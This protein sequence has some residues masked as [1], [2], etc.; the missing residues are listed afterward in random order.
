M[1]SEDN[2]PTAL[3]AY[4]FAGG[5]TLGV[6]K[7]FN[8]VGHLEDG[9]FG[10]ETVKRNQPGFPIF[11]DR[12]AW[13]ID[14][15][16]DKVD[17]IYGNPP[18]VSWSPAGV[19]ESKRLAGGNFQYDN[20]ERTNCAKFMFELLFQIRPKVYVWESVVNA[21]IAGRP[22]VNSF[23][24]R[25][26]ETGYAVS[27]VFLNGLHCGIAHHRRRWFF[28]VHRV[29]FTPEKPMVKGKTVQ[30]AIGHLIDP[31]RNID[32][33][34]WKAT[35]G[36]ELLKLTPPGAGAMD[37]WRAWKEQEG[38][39]VDLDGKTFKPGFLMTRAPWTKPCG[40]PIGNRYFHPFE[41]R[42]L[43]VL[44]IQLICG[45]PED[46]T[47]CEKLD[48]AYK[49]IT[50]AVMPPVGD[51]LGKQVRRAVDANAPLIY[52]HQTFDFISG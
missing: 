37:G 12:L 6:K 9:D 24:K 30:E 43:S 32:I 29:G 46:Y 34:R 21:S 7:H 5:F 49:E 23:I 52:S 41:D 50:Q 35:P 4:I 36:F 3:G 38:K 47:F 51:W 20:D 39:K 31:G 48:T 2:K 15:Y 33:D 22:L 11:T 40:V 17:F 45:Y 13:P 44:E 27:E 19:S 14:R 18:C 42:H 26:N 8:V 10:V 1:N 16:A 25:A 28:V